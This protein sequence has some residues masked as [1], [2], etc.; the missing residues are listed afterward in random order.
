ML[1]LGAVTITTSRHGI[2]DGAARIV[3]RALSSDL[4]LEL[5]ILKATSG[6]VSCGSGFERESGIIN[7]IQSRT[8]T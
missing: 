7:S 2:S 1:D 3:E 8:K 4:R 6:R 5:P